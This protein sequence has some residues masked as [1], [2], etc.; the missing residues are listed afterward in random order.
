MYLNEYNEE[1]NAD[2]CILAWN[3]ISLEMFPKKMDSEFPSQ[4]TNNWNFLH[5]H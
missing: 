3:E 2:E 4:H 1:F 5:Y